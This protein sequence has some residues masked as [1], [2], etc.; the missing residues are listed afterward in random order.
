MPDAPRHGVFLTATIC[1]AE[2]LTLVGVF[3]FPALLPVFFDEWSLSNTEAGWIAGIY[4]GANAAVVGIMVSLTDRVDARLVYLFGAALAAIGS[5]GFALFAEGFWTALAFRGLAGVGL[6][7]TYIPGLRALTDRY[8]GRH[9]PRAV[10]VYTGA[11]S[12]GSALSFLVIGQVAAV[13]GWRWS[14]AVAAIAAVLALVIVA[15]VLR[16]VRPQVAKEETRLLDIRPVLRNRRAMAYI[17]AYGVHAWELTSLRSWTVA[18]LAFALAL[19]GDGAGWLVPTTVAMLSAIIAMASSIVGGEMGAHFGPRRWIMWVMACSSV[20]GAM[21]GFSAS[22][23]YL[24]VVALLLFFAVLVQ[25]DAGVINS[26]TLGAAEPG[27]RGITLAVHSM[28]G[29]VCAFLAPLVFGIVLDLAGGGT[30]PLAWGL[31]FATIGA[32]VL[33]GPLALALLGRTRP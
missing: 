8:E 29:F 32:A 12:L 3:A 13:W 7:G 30:E 21:L 15:L 28:F 24:S 25:A 27:R 17:V 1:V 22:L 19:G 9:Q 18:F 14:F 5:A 31:A 23:P 26:G 2:V 10:A 33:L 4:F 11:F 20:T 16:P 6:A